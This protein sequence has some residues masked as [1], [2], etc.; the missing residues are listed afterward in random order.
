M[1]CM[2]DASDELGDLERLAQEAGVDLKVV[3]AHAGFAMSTWWRWKEK[4]FEPQARSLRRIRSAIRE[5]AA[6]GAA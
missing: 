6:E 2:I 4:K 1:R 5:L 3:V